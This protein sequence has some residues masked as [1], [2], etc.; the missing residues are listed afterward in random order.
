MEKFLC[1]VNISLKS[2]IMNK[3]FELSDKNFVHESKMLVESIS[4]SLESH[5]RY[6]SC[7]NEE[8]RTILDLVR[9]NFD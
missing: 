3:K 6:F 4:E 9:D 7:S 2:C 8:I 1:Q 5:K